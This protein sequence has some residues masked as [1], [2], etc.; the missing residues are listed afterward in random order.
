M[1]AQTDATFVQGVKKFPTVAR[2]PYFNFQQQFCYVNCHVI[3]NNMK[4]FFENVKGHNDK[5]KSVVCS[6]Q[7]KSF[8]WLYRKTQPGDDGTK[9]WNLTLA[10][11]D[12]L[13][14]HINCIIVPL[15]YSQDFQVVNPFQQTDVLNMK[16]KFLPGTTLMELLIHWSSKPFDIA[17]KAYYLLFSKASNSCEKSG[18]WMINCTNWN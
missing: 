16:G 18:R 9:P 15:G 10:S 11:R 17:Y 12:K 2:L 13:D 6:Q 1:K 14:A 5:H 8:P 7:T 4:E 3:S